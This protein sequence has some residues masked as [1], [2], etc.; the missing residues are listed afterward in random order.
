MYM[1]LVAYRLM[2]CKKGTLMENAR[3]YSIW[4]PEGKF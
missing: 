2:L 4:F 1:T 3:F